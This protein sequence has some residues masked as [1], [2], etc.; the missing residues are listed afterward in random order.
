MR[1]G[2]RGIKIFLLCAWI[3]LAF[4]A[5]TNARENDFFEF[6]IVSVGVNAVSRFLRFCGCWLR[7]TR[8]A[9]KIISITNSVLAKVWFAVENP[10]LLLV[11]SAAQL[12]R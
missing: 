11:R 3:V 10:F 4:I 1:L 7:T 9:V 12:E 8:Q 2:F 5:A 6:L